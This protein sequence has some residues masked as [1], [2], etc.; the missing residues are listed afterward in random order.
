[1]CKTIPFHAMAANQIHQS[2]QLLAKAMDSLNIQ[3]SY[4]TEM[5]NKA[6]I[7]AFHTKQI[8]KKH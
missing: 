2:D 3:H 5:N 8:E 6:R 1:M 7:I 4:N